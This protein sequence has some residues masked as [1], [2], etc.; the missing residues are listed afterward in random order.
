MTEAANQPG[1]RALL[2]GV[3]KYPNLPLHSQLRG[4]VNDVEI[5]QQTLETLFGFPP[6]NINVLRD[7]EA[8][9]DEIRAAMEKLVADCRPD[10]IVVFHFSGHGSQMPA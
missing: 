10:D 6:G 2:I 8:T 5:M 9:A 3:N 7:E 4:C 1:K